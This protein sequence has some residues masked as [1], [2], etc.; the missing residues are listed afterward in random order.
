MSVS[1]LL[2]RQE[3]HLKAE[4]V[5]PGASPTICISEIEWKKVCRP[6]P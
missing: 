5:S 1:K 4:G 2:I 3:R 6:R